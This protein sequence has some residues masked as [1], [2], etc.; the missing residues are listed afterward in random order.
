M[1]AEFVECAD[2]VRKSELGTTITFHRLRALHHA[3]DSVRALQKSFAQ[4]SQDRTNAL[5]AATQAGITARPASAPAGDPRG[6][7]ATIG[8]G[9]KAS[10]TLG[11]PSGANRGDLGLQGRRE[12]EPAAQLQ[13]IENELQALSTAAVTPVVQKQLVDLGERKTRLLLRISHET[14]GR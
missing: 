7:L 9:S 11:S 8:S 3:G 6:Q 14:G 1:E 5:V 4:E 12:P 10:E 13:Q 2:P